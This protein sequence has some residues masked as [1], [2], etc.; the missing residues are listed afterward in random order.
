M[1]QETLK[2]KRVCLVWYLM[3]WIKLCKKFSIGLIKNP[4]LNHFLFKNSPKTV[5]KHAFLNFVWQ[6][7]PKKG[8]E[9]VSSSFHCSQKIQDLH[10]LPSCAVLV[11]VSSELIKSAVL[12]CHYSLTASAHR[13]ASI[14][15]DRSSSEPR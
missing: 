6:L 7:L 8:M 5:T 12:L 4:L 10:T 11:T 3:T 9:K 13:S 14:P 1:R 2:G 15:A